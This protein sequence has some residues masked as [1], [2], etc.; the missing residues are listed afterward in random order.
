MRLLAQHN[1]SECQ[2][3]VEASSKAIEEWVPM[4]TALR[5]VPGE[6]RLL[7]VY[8]SY[9]CPGASSLVLID[10]HRCADILIREKRQEEERA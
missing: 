3:M 5:R 2:D 4:M 6:W 9:H 7:Q 10:M 1:L 8:T